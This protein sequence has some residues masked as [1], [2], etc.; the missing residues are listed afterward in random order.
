[1]FQQAESLEPA[2]ADITYYIGQVYRAQGNFQSALD[3]YQTAIK[4][5]GNFAP[6]FL[7]RALVNLDLDPQAD[8]TND[9]NGAIS[10]DPHYAEAYIERG[11]YRLPG[12]PAAAESDFE[13]A[14]EITPDSALAHL[15]LA[16]A[17]LAQGENDAALQS[18]QRANQ[19]DITLIPVYLALAQAYIATDQGE[20]AIG[21]L[22]TYTIYEPNDSDAFLALGTAYNA[23]GQYQ[24]ALNVLNKA[25]DAKRH[26]AEAYAQRGYAYLYLQ[27]SNL[28]EADFKAAITYNPQDFD[29]QLGLARVYDMQ[30]KPGDAYIQVDQKAYPLAKTNKTKAQV[31]YWEALY[32]EEIGE[33]LSL[34][35]ANN[36][37]NNL[38]ALPADAMPADW[39]TQ[40][41]HYLNITPTFTPTF[42]PTITSTFSATSTPTPSPSKTG[43]PTATK[44]K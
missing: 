16:D 14:I 43:T 17:Q 32:L 2:A 19:I 37:W 5:D 36:A 7:G 25:I 20:R 33:K 28:A 1:M 30:K 38:I 41:Y 18:A 29:A 3:A 15:Y 9:L 34:Q 11:K 4:K 23:A 26:Y 44:G 27:D 6:A 35:G 40:A 31:Y 10:L 13:A 22:Q 21:V 24:L 12:N 39:R 8:V 42:F